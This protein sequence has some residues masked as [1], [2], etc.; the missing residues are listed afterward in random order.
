MA[1]ELTS[2]EIDRVRSLKQALLEWA[3]A[4]RE[5]DRCQ[6]DA[7]AGSVSSHQVRLAQERDS[8]AVVEVNMAR[9]RL[10]SS[11]LSLP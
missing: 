8:V 9:Q 2:E 3:E 1:P 5:L 10:W 4:R 7:N 6:R 11:L